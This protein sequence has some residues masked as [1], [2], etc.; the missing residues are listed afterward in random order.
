MKEIDLKWK[1]AMLTMRDKRALRNQDNKH[2]KS[3]KRSVPV[4][5]PAFIA[6]VSCDGL[7]G[8]DWSDQAEEGPNYALVAYTSS[9]SDSKV[10]NDSTYSKTC[11]ETFKLFKAQNEELLKDLKKSELMVLAYKT[12]L[13]LVEERL[14][15]L[16]KIEFIY[17]GD[18]K[19]LK[20]EIQ[21][22][23]IAIKE[24]R[25]KLEVAQKDTNDIQLKLGYENYNV[26][27]PPYIGNFMPLKL[28]LSFTGLDEFV[29]EPED[30]N[31]H[32][33]SSEEETKVVRK[34]DD[35]IIIEE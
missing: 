29:N 3:T 28:D 20:V 19:V 27:P 13:K 11:F 8:Y 16:K 22:K 7:G 18:I 23:D 15:F 17:L 10:S 9:P 21:M 31:S 5:T 12:G 35:A 32:V 6:L 26:V 34:N 24:L 1:I 33:K 30:K 4:E 14:E 2:K 25:R